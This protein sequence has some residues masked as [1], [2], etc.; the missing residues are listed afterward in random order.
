MTAI[1]KLG[2]LF[3]VIILGGAALIAYQGYQ[4]V[5]GADVQMQCGG[6]VIAIKSNLEIRLFQK[7]PEVRDAWFRLCSHQYEQ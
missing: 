4:H 7:H 3:S 6:D 5:W 1:E 2:S